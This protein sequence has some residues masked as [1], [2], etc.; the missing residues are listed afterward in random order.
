[1]VLKN[2]DKTQRSQDFY[3]QVGQRNFCLTVSAFSTQKDIGK[4]R[5]IVIESNLPFALGAGG[6]RPQKTHS[7]G[8]PVDDHIQ[9]ASPG[10]SK[11]DDDDY[12]FHHFV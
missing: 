12:L 2:K 10:Q 5:D 6:W 11:K 3:E 9:K 8:E 7:Q 1:M 4:D